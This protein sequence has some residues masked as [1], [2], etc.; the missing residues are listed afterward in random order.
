MVVGVVASSSITLG[1]SGPSAPVLEGVWENISVTSKGGPNPDIAKRPPNINIWTKKYFSRVV[2]AA[3][4][5]VLAPPKDPAALTEAEKLARYD[6]WTGVVGVAGA[7]QQKGTTWMQYASVG[8][9]QTADTIARQTNPTAAPAV[10]APGQAITFEGSTLVLTQTSADGKTV[11][12]RT[13]RRL[14]RPRPAGATPHPIEGVW[15]GTS[16]VATGAAPASN[17]NRQPNVF[18]YMNGYY[19]IVRQDGGVPLPSRPVLPAPK[20]PNRLTS[21]EKLARYDHWV[22]VAINAGRYEVKGSALYQ[23]DLIAKNQTAD[24]L[25]R[26]KSG[27]LGTVDPNSDLEFSNNNNTM[28]QISRSADGKTI[29][30]RTY[31]RLE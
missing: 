10:A 6:H 16:T 12:R 14:D 7:Y 3:G 22:P 21:A 1:Q 19:T 27:N 13:Y 17:P 20:D 11:T 2:D 23:Y 8:N 18:I 15:K 30:R 26:Q 4:R 31:V 9:S 25:S 29:S 5:E 24:I 28:V